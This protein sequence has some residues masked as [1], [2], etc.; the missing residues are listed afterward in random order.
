[1]AF[2]SGYKKRIKWLSPFSFE[3]CPRKIVFHFIFYPLGW[4][5]HS[6][7]SFYPLI[8]HTRLMAGWTKRGKEEGLCPFTYRQKKNVL[9]DRLVAQYKQI[10]HCI[11]VKWCIWEVHKILQHCDRCTDLSL[12]LITLGLS[13]IT[14]TCRHISKKDCAASSLFCFFTI[15]NALQQ[16][17]NNIST[18]WL[19]MSYYLTF[20]SMSNSINFKSVILE[21]L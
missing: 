5:C 14:R 11:N 21:I 13:C 6:T 10:N 3:I 18:F 20:V 1:M 4:S 16:Q 12:F 8:T 17:R 2:Q 9:T 7:H 15:K 19:Q